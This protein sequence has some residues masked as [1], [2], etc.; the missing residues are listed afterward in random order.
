M[1]RFIPF[2]RA[3]TAMKVEIK[4]LNLLSIA[5]A[6]KLFN[7]KIAPIA[8]YGIQFIWNHLIWNLK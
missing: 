6:L 4:T 2:L 5:T 3:V 7:I 1:V 8:T